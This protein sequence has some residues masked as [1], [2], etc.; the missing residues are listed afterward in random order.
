[1][2]IDFMGENAYFHKWH[3]RNQGNQAQDQNLL[4]D[5]SKFPSLCI[6]CPT[7]SFYQLRERPPVRQ[8]KLLSST[9]E[10]LSHHF[11]FSKRIYIAFFY[12][13]N[14]IYSV[15]QQSQCLSHP[16]HPPH[17]ALV[18]NPF[19]SRGRRNKCRYTVIPHSLGPFAYRCM[20]IADSETSHH[21]SQ[22]THTVNV[23]VY[24]HGSCSL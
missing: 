7:K 24:Y 4:R 22:V 3:C 6:E 10:A 18:A 21:C 23:N 2:F 9:L 16:Y 12:S 5:D 13:L 14:S 20:Y 15:L 1:M 17:R 19:S 8:F 11:P